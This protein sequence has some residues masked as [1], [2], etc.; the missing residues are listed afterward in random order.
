[1]DLGFEMDFCIEAVVEIFD[2]ISGE[3]E[4]VELLTSEQEFENSKPYRIVEKGIYVDGKYYETNVTGWP[5]PPV[6]HLFLREPE[7]S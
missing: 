1:M 6:G 4:V 2:D 7:T 3:S 5:I